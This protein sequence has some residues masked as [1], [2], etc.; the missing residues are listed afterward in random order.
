[1]SPV[2]RCARPAPAGTGQGDL[3]TV[4]RLRAALLAA[5]C[6]AAL[7]QPAGARDDPAGRWTPRA[8]LPAPRRLL[9]AAVFTDARG[10]EAIYTFGGCGSPC[11][12][13][14]LHGSTDEE[15]R[16]EIYDPR[17]DRWRRA[18]NRIP[19]VVFGAAAAAPGDGAIYIVGGFITADTVA[20]GLVATDAVL[21]YD[22]ARDAWSRK[23]PLPT[24]RLGLAAVALNDKVYALGGSD[25]RA[26]TGAM[27]VYDPAT[28]RWTPAASLPTPRAFLAA[29]VLDGKIY[30]VGGAPDCCGASTTAAVEVYDPA[31]DR[32]RAVRPLPV[33]LQV[34]AAA[35]VNGRLYVLGGFIPG[36]G[37]QGDTYEYDPDNDA[38]TP[39]APLLVPR[40]QAPAVAA[41]GEIYLLGGSNDCHCR[42][43][44]ANH[45]FTPAAPL[46][47]DLGIDLTNGR[48]RLSRSSP[49]ATRSPSPTT[50]RPTPRGLASPPSFRRCCEGCRGPAAP[51]A[52]RAAAARGR[53][54]ASPPTSRWTSRPAAR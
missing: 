26:A 28:G 34:S 11:Y 42:A 18:A 37:V 38:W 13:P 15:T 54:A 10:V 22:P 25:G 31:T 1:M 46:P 39:R 43:L 32:W 47:A 9:A 20:G 19:A 17:T 2:H 5:A 49:C 12:Q 33:A 14:P 41:G 44:D 53:S 24:P 23:A 27:D 16:V 40:D 45:R 48:T 7:A 4:P 36:R 8:P 35:A 3:S 29:T 51:R 52:A 21:A 6:A 30:A 50:A